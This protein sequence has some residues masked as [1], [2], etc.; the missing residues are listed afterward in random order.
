MFS[1]V[2]L[3]PRQSDILDFLIETH[4]AQGMTPTYREIADRFGFKSTRAVADH[5]YALE[6]RDI[7]AVVP[8]VPVASN[9]FLQ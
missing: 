1:I 4:R 8:G 3:T 6:K 7:Y 5:I 9:C 2:K